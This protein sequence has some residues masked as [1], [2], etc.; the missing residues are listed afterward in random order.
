GKAD[1]LDQRMRD[2]RFADLAVPALNEAEH[3]LRHT[4][5]GDGG[6]NGFGNDLAGSRMGGM[7]FHDHRAACGKGGCRVAASGR[8]SQ[9]KIGGPEHGNRTNRTLHQPDFRTWRWFSVRQ[10]LIN[11]AIQIVALADV[12]G[13][14]AK[15]SGGASTLAFKTACRQTGFLR[16]DFR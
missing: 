16:A 11:A 3:A 15:L 1:S 5:P 2:Q 8:E 4:R 12:T 9:W 14:K 7:T 13:E 10:G 6:M